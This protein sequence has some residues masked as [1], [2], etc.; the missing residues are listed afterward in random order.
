MR[1]LHRGIEYS[2]PDEWWVEAGM[3]GFAVPRHSFLAGPSQWLDLPVF[4]VAVEEVRPLLRNGSHGVFNDSPESGSAHDRVVRI[5][6]GFR[7]DAAIPPVEIA[8]LADGSGPRFKLVHG[9][10]RFYCGVAAGF[11]QVPAVEAV[12]IWGDSTGEA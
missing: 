11:S 5:L 3:E 10:H 6:R 1:F 9:V 2:L 4:H 8:R 7:D 12:D